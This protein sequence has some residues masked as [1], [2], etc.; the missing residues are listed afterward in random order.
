MIQVLS[1][2]VRLS[3]R[4]FRPVTSLFFKDLALA[5][6]QVRAVISMSEWDRGDT[7][8]HISLYTVL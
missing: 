6:A 5:L 1:V 8:H 3:A 2:Q 7:V 4:P